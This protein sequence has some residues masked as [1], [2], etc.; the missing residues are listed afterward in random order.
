MIQLAHALL[1]ATLATGQADTAAGCGDQPAYQ[2][3]DFWIGKWDVYA[4]GNLDGH[5]TV[6]RVLGGCAVTEE[7][8]DANG[9][10]GLSLFYY[11]PATQEWK[12]VWVTDHATRAGGVK[13]KKLVARLDGGGVQFQGT[14]IGPQGH[15]YLDRTTLTPLPS[16]EVHQVIEF[17]RDQGASWKVVYD[18]VYRK[19]A[20]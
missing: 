20:T 8:A 15:P 1:L 4:D 2:L 6:A 3:L 9:S 11:L 17:S 5:D 14:V 18:A 16:G 12:Q 7:W 13:E 19:S 10:K